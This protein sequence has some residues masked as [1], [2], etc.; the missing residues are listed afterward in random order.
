MHLLHPVLFCNDYDDVT[1]VMHFIYRT[2]Q[3]LNKLRKNTWCESHNKVNLCLSTIVPFNEYIERVKDVVDSG[4]YLY[5]KCDGK[6]DA[7]LACWKNLEEDQ[8]QAVATLID[9][10]YDESRADCTKETWEMGNIKK[11]LNI[12]FVTLVD[13]PKF[14]ASYLATLGNDSIFA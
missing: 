7:M 12:E 2:T 13:L 6:F 5:Y 8:C 11:Y 14:R 9:S 4:D 1:N 3:A 10:F